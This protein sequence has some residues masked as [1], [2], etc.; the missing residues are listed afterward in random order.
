MDENQITLINEDGEE[1]LATILFTHE[2]NGKNYVVFELEESGDISAARYIEGSNGEGE[3]D[4]ID[5]E[6]EWEMLD[7]L[8]EQYFDQLD[9]DI[10]ESDED[11]ESDE[12]N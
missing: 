5:S 10:Y 8:V 11:E 6:E 4:D 12:E 1:Q 3:L 2:E 7:E 9:D